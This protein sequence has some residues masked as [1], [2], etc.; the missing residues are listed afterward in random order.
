MGVVPCSTLYTPLTLEN[1]NNNRKVGAYRVLRPYSSRGRATHGARARIEQHMQ[2]NATRRL[3]VTVEIH[4][5]C[6]PRDTLGRREISRAGMA[7]VQ[8]ALRFV[9]VP[10]Y[11]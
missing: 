11:Y 4:R 9:S 3:P 1:C 10:P 8:V 7:R 5:P 6:A 2:G